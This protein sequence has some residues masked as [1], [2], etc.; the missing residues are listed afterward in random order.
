[1]A[2]EF[3]LQ[4]FYDH[5]KRAETFLGGDIKYR[6]HKNA[7]RDFL[8]WMDRSGVSTDNKGASPGVKAAQAAAA[9]DNSK[10]MENRLKIVDDRP[11]EDFQGRPVTDQPKSFEDAAEK[12]HE[13]FM[14]AVTGEKNE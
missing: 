11:R 6:H 14:T 10:E 5:A 1:M 8:H 13:Q 4:E 7:L 2:D 12:A 9:G 3:D